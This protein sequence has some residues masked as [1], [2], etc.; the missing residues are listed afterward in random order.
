MKKL[1][2]LILALASALLLLASCMPTDDN[3]DSGKENDSPLRIGY[4]SGPTGMGMAKLIN[5][6][7]GKDGNDKYTFTSYTNTELAKADLTKG[8]IDVICIPTNEALAYYSNVDSKTRVLAINCLNSLY[9]ISDGENSATSLA[10]LEGKTVYTCK[11]GTPRV[12]LEY[13]IEKLSLDI[14]VSYTV[15]DKDMN[16]PADVSAQVISGAL[17]YAVIPEPIITSSLLKNNSYS[18]DVNLADEWAKIDGH[19]NTPVAM[20]CIVASADFIAEN[21]SVIESFLTEY[22]ASIEFMN[23]SENLDLASK[24]VADAGIMAAAPAAKKAL[25]NLGDAISYVDGAAMKR[26]LDAFYKA[27]GMSAPDEF[28]YA[29]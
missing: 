17:P 29:K 7:G 27:L 19:E 13:I 18:V 6:N 23:K 25:S 21:S 9:L 16:T 5:D 26:T 4:M 8:N 10:D 15:N 2:A 11:N 12:I 14:T 3:K 1:I 24:Y 20:G 22:K 28:Y